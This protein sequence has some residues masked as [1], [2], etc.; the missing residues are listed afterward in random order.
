VYKSSAQS[1]FIGVDAAVRCVSPFVQSTHR[2]GTYAT[3]D[4]PMMRCDVLT[5]VAYASVLSTALTANAA[6][7][8]DRYQLQ[9]LGVATPLAQ[10][11]PTQDVIWFGRSINANGIAVGLTSLGSPANS[12]AKAWGQPP[13]IRD[14]G[15]GWAMDINLHGA[16]AG[17][18]SDSLPARAVVWSPSGQVIA[19]PVLAGA[20]FS[21][22][23]A[24]N[25]N[26]A[27]VGAMQFGASG[28]RATLWTSGGAVLLPD[29]PAGVGMA[30]ATDVNASGVV[31]GYSFGVGFVTRGFRWSE[32]TGVQALALPAGAISVE[33]RAINA[34]GFIVGIAS[35][36]SLGE[37][38][39]LWP[40][41]GEV[42][43][44]PLTRA[45]AIN[46]A[47]MVVGFALDAASSFNGVSA[48]VWTEARGMVLLN[49]R[50]SPEDRAQW[51]L[52][53]ATAI[54][55]AGQIV[56]TACNGA[57]FDDGTAAVLLT[58]A[59]VC[60][61]IDFNR[62]GVFPED[63]DVIDFFQVLAGGDCA[64]CGDIDFN[65]NDVFPEDEDVV[66]FFRVLA[67]GTC[68]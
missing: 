30:E 7:V 58:P 25:D 5:L 31:I 59:L 57:L 46:D 38:A 67:G 37:R 52:V 66:A 42:R 36:P 6:E 44:L 27:V 50:L 32:T 60:D 55:N 35:G 64:T 14:L 29:L 54:N 2:S 12:R 34:A 28:Q 61:A 47:G 62:N 51:C 40:P 23:N 13:L 1:A 45:N 8:A 19:L 53:E 20:T 16:V 17:T 4:S 33:P 43:V 9:L 24:V 68:E 65:N 3:G 41:S 48:A 21:L 26:G 22:A 39:V 18:R 11:N 49:D 10:P 15:A 63:Q 56:A